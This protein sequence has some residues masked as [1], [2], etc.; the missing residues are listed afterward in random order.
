MVTIGTGNEGRERGAWYAAKAKMEWD[1]MA[2]VST[3]ST[4]VQY[5]LFQYCSV[6]LLSFESETLRLQSKVKAADF[7]N[8]VFEMSLKSC[9]T[10]E[11]IT[12][13][14]PHK[15]KKKRK[16]DRPMMSLTM[17]APGSEETVIF[18]RERSTFRRQ[19]VRRRHNAGSNPTPPTSLIGSPL[20]YAVH[21]AG[22]PSWYEHVTRRCSFLSPINTSL[23]LLQCMTSSKTLSMIGWV[24]PL[25]MWCPSSS[26]SQDFTL[27]ILLSYNLIF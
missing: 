19:A 7:W 14:C 20:R 9:L 1:V 21:G 27:F 2:H 15:T 11:N 17:T 4:P 8:F 16:S 3:I 24:S 26:F 18:R 22:N 10:H 23:R 5:T 13:Y 12:S 6:M 25:C